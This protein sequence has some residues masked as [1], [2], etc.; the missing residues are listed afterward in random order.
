MAKYYADLNPLFPSNGAK[1]WAV[2]FRGEE[3]NSAVRIG[4]FEFVTRRAAE[5]NAARMNA[6]MRR[7]AAFEQLLND[8]NWVG[9]RHHY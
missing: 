6:N 8:P 2:F 7:Q 5:N 4:G 9:S 3:K 1:K